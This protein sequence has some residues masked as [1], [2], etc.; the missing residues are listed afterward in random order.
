M[1]AT[2]RGYPYPLPTDPV[3][4][5]PAVGQTLATKLDNGPIETLGDV[6]SGKGSTGEL[7]IGKNGSN[8]PAIWWG[9]GDWYQVMTVAGELD[10]NVNLKSVHMR[11][12]RHP[13]GGVRHI[14]SG[15]LSFGPLNINQKATMTLT[16]TDPYASP[17]TTVLGASN[18]GDYTGGNSP[19]AAPSY[20]W[21]AGQSG[22][23]SVVSSVNASNTT[24]TNIYVYWMAEGSD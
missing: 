15:V 11:V 10:T 2:P 24:P 12:Q 21:C 22:A 18:P 5:Y 1:A 23:T 19:G 3:A 9:V 17:P 8:Q 7:R 16:F 6:T 4:D 14:E 13:F 20:A